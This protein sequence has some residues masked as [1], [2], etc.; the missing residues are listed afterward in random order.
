MAA[1][2]R[3]PQA[4]QSPRVAESLKAK[5]PKAEALLVV[6]YA[7]AD[8]KYDRW[9][10][11][12][13]PQ[14][15]D[16]ASYPFNGKDAFGR[17]AV[18][19]FAKAP[20][21]AGFIVR[22][23]DWEAKDI[24][25]D[26]TVAFDGGATR[27][28]WL[29][30]GDERV[31]T[32][33][34]DIDLS[35]RVEGAFL[36]SA[37]AVTLATSAPL[38]AEQLQ[39][40][41][42]TRRGGG[43]VKIAG[44]EPSRE[45]GS[46]RPLYEVKLLKPVADADVAALQI[47]V[48][49]GKPQPVY[50]R[51]VLDQDRFTPL[52]ARLGALCTPQKTVFQTWSPVSEGVQLLL[53]DKPDAKE[54]FLKV[55]MER[56]EKGVWSTTVPG[57]LHGKLYRYRFDS[58]GLKRET[59]DIH[60]FAATADDAFSVAADLDRLNPKA[61]DETAAPTLAHPT[62]EIIY[63]VHVR[64]YSI[65]DP[66]CP[67]AMRGKYLGLTHENPPAD[68]GVSSGLSHLKELGVTAVHLLPIQDFTAAANEYNWGYWTALF[69]VPESNYAAAGAEPDPLQ[70]LQPLRDARQMIQSLHA[71]GLRVILDVVYNHTSS[72][73]AASPFDQTVPFYF[74]RTTIDGRLLD[75][76]GVGNTFADERPMARKYIL[77]S[78]AH[79][80][81]SYK[82]DGFRFDLLGTHQPETVKAICER[83]VALRPDV[84]LYGEPWTGGGA[85]HFGKGAQKGMRIGVFNDNL[86]NAVRGDLDGT[87]TGFATGA[88]GDA[89][90]VR[91]GVAGSIDDFARE[92]GESVNYVAAHDNLTLWD[93]L[94]KAQPN[95]DDA[96]RR[97][98][99]KLAYGIVL[100][101]Q[102]VAFLDGGGEFCRTKGG[103]PNSYNA[104]DAVNAFDWKRKQ[105]YLD[106]HEFVRGLIELRRAHPAFRM[107]DAAAIRRSIRFL[108]NAGV[109]SFTID[110][111]AA[112]DSWREIVVAYN[113]QSTPQRVALPPGGWSV[114]VDATRAGT[115]TLR[116]ASGIVELPAH[117]MLVGQRH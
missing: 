109:V 85:I 8:K 67:W 32:D 43:A 87:A 80:T 102:G 86:R 11:W 27:E 94:L 71:A 28:I 37:G 9:N 75:D 88:G 52:D 104:G 46:S 110:G 34:K 18:V 6:H 70:P 69:N 33:P 103:N 95:A 21:G 47:E 78:L 7:R 55:P 111:A 17:Y 96:A 72:T 39:K 117:S 115:D 13:W 29:V 83:I 24:D 20:S 23:G 68:G 56:G 89:A 59:V 36:D 98:M 81:T 116:T 84:T 64:D 50:A 65:N 97:A 10:L 58:Y 2:P 99:Q 57:D 100:T 76:T 74:H 15:G 114:V 105:A 16:G 35:V 77:D 62:D 53:Y 12:C 40:T 63:E 49:G 51:R 38:S 25:H 44:V 91:R 73:G 112:G 60:A 26:R 66:Q 3:A 79:W 54:P 41:R 106:V 48:P 22:L 4:V 1:A 93:K 45:S 101:S 14:G 42:I 113:G 5:N 30:A 107:A 90:A 92:P 19:P 61:W 108:D 82:V 31:Y